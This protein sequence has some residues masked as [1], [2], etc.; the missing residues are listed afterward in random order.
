M[1]NIDSIVISPGPGHP[2][3]PQ[4]FGMCMQVML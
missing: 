2:A 1:C 4:D 3:L